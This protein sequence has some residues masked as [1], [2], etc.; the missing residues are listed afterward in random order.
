MEEPRGLFEGLVVTRPNREQSR[1][2]TLTLPLSIAAH[3]VVFSA[4]V[5]IPVLTSEGL[6]DP[7][8]S[9]VRAFF[10]EPGTAAPPPPPPAP[11]PGR[12]PP[13]PPPSLL[14]WRPPIKSCPKRR[15]SWDSIPAR[16][17]WRAGCP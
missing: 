6:P 13:P 1:G 2:R 9:A 4:M 17:G 14:P 5:V 16:T 10:T 8:G 11:R 12:P 15:G 3:V 7:T